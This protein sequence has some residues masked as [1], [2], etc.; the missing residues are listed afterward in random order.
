[1]AGDS[2]MAAYHDQFNTLPTPRTRLG[3]GELERGATMVEYAILIM[4]IVL[5][6]IAALQALG[7]Q[8]SAQYSGI[9][10]SVV[11]ASSNN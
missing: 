8:V 3:D 6:A 4:L 11:D 2:I 1:M 9:A 7:G 5:V 10:S